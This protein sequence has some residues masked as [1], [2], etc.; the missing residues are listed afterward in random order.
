MLKPGDTIGILG[1][2]QLGRM[3]AM[4]AARLGLKAH[5]Y[6]PEAESPAFDL[7][8]AHTIAAYED[9]NAL[10]RFAR[11]VDLITLEFENVPEASL[12][13]LTNLKPVAP[14]ADA[15]A[16]TQDRLSEK[17]F[18]RKIGLEPAPFIPVASLEALGAALDG[19]GLPAILKTRRLGYD[20]KG[21]V[22][23]HTVDE[24]AA[25]WEALGGALAI[26][27]GFVPFTREVSVVAARTAKGDF[28]A[29]DA[30]ENSHANHI[31]SRSVVPAAIKPE[32]MQAALGHAKKIGDGLNYVGVFAVEFF[33][34]EEEGRE[35]VLGNEIA[36]RV[37]NSGHWTIDGAL[38]CQFEQHIRAIAGWPLGDTKRRG[39][40]EMLNLIG[41]EAADWLEILRDP[42]AKLHLYGKGETRAGRKM[43]HVTRIS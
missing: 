3:L 31:L 26:L 43:G 27:E 30:I 24:A 9:E 4:A 12:R 14:G 38:T 37:H 15:L 33:V 17:R 23:I 10:A 25:A 42:C 39:Q 20:G 5:L 28:A 22:K 35:W 11:S 19:I 16:I 7:A 2:G 21:Q 41:I 29:F 6:C 32:T 34:C 8:A 36:P 1:G 18:L 40:V 13:F